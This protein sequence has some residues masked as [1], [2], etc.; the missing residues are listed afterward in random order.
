MGD[1]KKKL[2]TQEDIM[3]FLDDCYRKCINGIPVV[4]P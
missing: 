3:K 4:S 2:I 1:E